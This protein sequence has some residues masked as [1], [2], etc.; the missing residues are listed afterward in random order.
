MS[1]R[2]QFILQSANYSC[3]DLDEVVQLAMLCKGLT[4][5]YKTVP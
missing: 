5:M 2:L 3:A 1:W 4:D